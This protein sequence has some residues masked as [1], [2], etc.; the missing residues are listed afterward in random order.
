MSGMES[1][2]LIRAGAAAAALL[3]QVEPA[4]WTQVVTAVSIAVLAVMGVGV[5]IGGLVAVRAVLRLLRTVE[6]T[7]EHVSPRAEPL[8]DKVGR[9]AD[10]ASE[11]TRS[12]RTEVDDVRKTVVDVNRQLR[13][14]AQAAETR[15]RRF[16]NVVDVVQEET[17]QL[18]LDATATARGI[19]ATAEALRRRGGG[20]GGLRSRP[21]DGG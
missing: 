19:H 16:A 15:A 3:L 18:L 13:A 1:Y 11:I 21:P 9:I 6:R 2:A 7:V 10:D 4:H 20:D 5:A 17:E 8:I 12:L 14:A